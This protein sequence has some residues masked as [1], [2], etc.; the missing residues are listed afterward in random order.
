MFGELLVSEKQ[1]SSMVRATNLSFKSFSRLYFAA[2][3]S[4][5]REG[6]GFSLWSAQ[7]VPAISWEAW[8]MQLKLGLVQH[9]GTSPPA[10]TQPHAPPPHVYH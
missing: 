4:L 9:G 10:I 7:V 2:R 1:V 6:K 8:K 3:F 5:K